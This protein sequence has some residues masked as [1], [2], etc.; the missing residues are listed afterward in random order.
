MKRK[1]ITILAA[2]ILLL[3]VHAH[4][5]GTYSDSIYTTW[6]QE[7]C[8]FA[9]CYDNLRPLG[10]GPLVNTGTTVS[11]YTLDALGIYVPQGQYPDIGAYEFIF[12]GGMNQQQHGFDMY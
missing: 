9:K 4:A 12:G 11:G 3:S 1:L 10:G 5:A 7:M 6:G 8:P 2:I